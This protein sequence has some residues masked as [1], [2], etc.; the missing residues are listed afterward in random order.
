MFSFDF[1]IKKNGNFQIRKV[2]SKKKCFNKF[3]IVVFRRDT[4][5]H[6][7]NKVGIKRAVLARNCIHQKVNLLNLRVLLKDQPQME[8]ARNCEKCNR[9]HKN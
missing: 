5:N 8:F 6:G 2:S 1:K 3:T 7:K 4:K 9:N